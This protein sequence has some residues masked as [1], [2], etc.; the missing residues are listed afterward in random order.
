MGITPDS[1]NKKMTFECFKEMASNTDLSQTEKIGFPDEYRAGFD[2]AIF[3]D[4]ANKLDLYQKELSVLD[5]GCG[6][7]DLVNFVIQNSIRYN[8]KLY[9]LDSKEMLSNI[10]GSIAVAECIAGQFPNETTSFIEKHQNSF[11]AII[12]YSLM[13]HIILDMNPFNFVDNLLIL[14]KP[15]GKVLLG[16]IPNIS[17]RN[18][19]FSSD[20]GV[21]F[22]R[23]FTKTDTVPEVKQ[24]ELQMDKF[25]DGMIFGI[26]NRYRG[27]GYETYLLPQ[28]STL[29]LYNRREDILI[30]KR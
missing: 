9:L 14:L 27:F 2:K 1:M 23:A 12:V 28:P 30:V 11:D 6:C 8:H 13:Q 26:L 5:L 19:F 4:I 21:R 29:P 16:D 20:Q 7:S 15:G 25:D 17:K 3:S 10:Q 22:H 18:R 24:F